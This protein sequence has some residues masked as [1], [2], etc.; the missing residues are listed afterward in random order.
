MHS[1]RIKKNNWKSPVFGFVFE[2]GDKNLH[3]IALLYKKDYS[4]PELALNSEQ[5]FIKIDQNIRITTNLVNMVVYGRK[6][7]YDHCEIFTELCTEF[8]DQQYVLREFDNT[9]IDRTQ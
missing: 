5:P 6:A 1:L 2:K 7:P 8:K 4:F 3:A 9:Q